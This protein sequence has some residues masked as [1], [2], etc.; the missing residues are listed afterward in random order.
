MKL[1]ETDREREIYNAAYQEGYDKG[2]LTG[3][4]VYMPVTNINKIKRRSKLCQD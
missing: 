1:P 2:Y 3:A 4:R